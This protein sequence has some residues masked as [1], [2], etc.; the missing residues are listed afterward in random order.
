[1][2]QT[3]ITIILHRLPLLFKVHCE[4]DEGETVPLKEEAEQSP[5]LFP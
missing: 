5:C 2:P 4:K 3:A 1:M